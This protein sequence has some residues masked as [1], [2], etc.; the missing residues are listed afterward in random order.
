MG[1]GS[2][3]N[4]ALGRESRVRASRE[5]PT[6]VAGGGEDGAPSWGFMKMECQC[7]RNAGV[8]RLRGNAA[9]LGMTLPFGVLA[10]QKEMQ[11]LRCAQDDK[12]DERLTHHSAA[13]PSS[14]LEPYLVPCTQYL[15]YCWR[16]T[17]SPALRPER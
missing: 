11:V 12:K 1:V 5:C 8:P 2:R 7:G 9:S 4:R 13:E 6:L 10:L 16:M 15:P 3:K 17:W 14:F